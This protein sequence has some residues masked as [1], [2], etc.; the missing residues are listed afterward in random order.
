MKFQIIIHF[1]LQDVNVFC[2]SL[3]YLLIII[4]F[5]L[6]PGGRVC[7]ASIDLNNVV[8]RLNIRFPIDYPN[9]VSPTFEFSSDT[10]IDHLIQAKLI[11]VI[12]NHNNISCS[13]CRSIA[14]LIPRSW[15]CL[16]DS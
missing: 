15:E 5:Q 11:K 8:I 7:V 2:T 4:F 10:D 9:G 14:R 1:F 16:P 3:F 13:L 6:D 12:A